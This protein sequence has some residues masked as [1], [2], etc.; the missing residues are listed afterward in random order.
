MDY[1]MDTLWMPLVQN[2]F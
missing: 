1:F 2:Y